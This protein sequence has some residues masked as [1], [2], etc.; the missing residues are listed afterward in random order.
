MPESANS[1]TKEAAVD[2]D[3]LLPDLLIAGGVILVLF[4]LLGL[5]VKRNSE[6]R[7]EEQESVTKNP[8]GDSREDPLF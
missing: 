2:D 1:N 4:G 6:V 8:K 7:A 5:L 3:I